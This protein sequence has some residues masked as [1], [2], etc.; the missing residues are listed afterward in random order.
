[1]VRDGVETWSLTGAERHHGSAWAQPFTPEPAALSPA[2]GECLGR[3]TLRAHLGAGGMGEVYAAHDPE[4]DRAVAVKVLRTCDGDA[5]P[6]AIARFQREVLA[7]ARLNHPNVVSVF[8]AGRV[9]DRVFVAMELVE[10]PTLASWLAARRRSWREVVGVFLQAG[11]GLAAAHAAGIV[12]RDFKP[13]NVIVGDRVRVADFGLAKTAAALDPPSSPCAATVALDVAIT[14]TGAAVGTPAY[15]APEQRAGGTVTPQADQYSYCVALREALAG[16]GPR[17]ESVEDRFAVRAPRFLRAVVAR[18]LASDPGD[19]FPSMAA[20]LEVLER[21]GGPLVRWGHRRRALAGLIALGALTAIAYVVPFGRA[22]ATEARIESLAVL[23]LDNLS[24]DPAQ[25]YI[26]DG[27]TESLI[28]E[29]GKLGSLRVI[30]RTAVMKY[31]GT[32]TPPS[33]IARELGVQALVAGSVLR[34]G[35]RLRIAVQLIDPQADRRTWSEVHERDLR[36]VLT[37]QREITVAIA[38]QVS[39]TLAAPARVHLAELHPVNPE[40]FKAVWQARFLSPRTTDIDTRETIALLERA[41]A[42]E[43]RFAQAY[44]DLAAAYVARQTFVNPGEA[45]ELEKQAI[46]AAAMA[47]SYDPELPEAHLARGD[48]LWTAS[49]R[50]D[51]VRAAGEFLTALRLNPSSDQAHARLARVV[52]HAG[53]FDQ[54][55]QHAASAL[56]INPLNAQARNTQAEALL[57]MGKAEDALRMYRRMPEPVLPELVEAHTVFALLRLNRREEATSRLELA[58]AKYPDDASGSLDGVQALL[59]AD[60]EPVRALALI[61][62]VRRRTPVNPAHHAAYFAACAYAHMR[63]PKEAVDWLRE[64]ADTGFPCHACFERDPNLAAI[65]QDPGFQALMADLQ[66]QSSSLARALSSDRP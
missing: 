24:G 63:R 47:Q 22:A 37:L 18:G 36:D 42:L 4:L 51:H 13:S 15:M 27:L 48:L 20:L 3:Y 39:A 12:H 14:R 29:L 58:R 16:H 7:M 56:E 8:D 65:R 25:D 26:A 34:S 50:F 1:M 17:D 62:S 64:A 2:L 59:L 21:G 28:A 5:T 49:Q 54:A 40:A 55:L 19:R 53:L 45:R 44:A 61:E 6:T 41:I 43:P 11:R 57:W 52:V 23:P 30:A 9:G 35:D 33:A 31:K 10:G 60:S 32:H 46:A 66:R 38:R